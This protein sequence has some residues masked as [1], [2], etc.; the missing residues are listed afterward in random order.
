MEAILDPASREA[1][2][3]SA[4]LEVLHSTVN[5]DITIYMNSRTQLSEI[6]VTRLLFVPSHKLFSLCIVYLLYC[7]PIV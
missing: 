4:F 6:P 2:K 1:Q 5:V 3:L 7:L